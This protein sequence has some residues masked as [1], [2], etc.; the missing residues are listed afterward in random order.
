MI[1]FGEYCKNL[2][3]NWGDFGRTPKEKY[4]NYCTN[5][6]VGRSVRLVRNKN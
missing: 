4:D 1:S 2:K 6:E 3:E 5:P